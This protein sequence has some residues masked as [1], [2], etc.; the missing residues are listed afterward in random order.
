MLFRRAT[1]ADIAGMSRVRMAVKENILSNPDLVT[2]A[3][4][5]EMIEEKGA[6]WVCEV[7]QAIVGFA[8]VDL[9]DANI[10]ALFVDP[11]HD[12]KGIG[13]KLHDLML[14]YSFEQ[15]TDKLWLST[16]P[17]TRAESFYRK[18]GWQQTGVTK[19]GEIR[20]E[21]ERGDYNTIIAV[22]RQSTL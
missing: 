11:N 18:A 12:K 20:F 15:G 3:S 6:G 4:Y 13:R 5:R 9:S 10:W 16:G 21:M 19:S 1:I 8:I 17:G 7:D 22:S 14:N 2:P